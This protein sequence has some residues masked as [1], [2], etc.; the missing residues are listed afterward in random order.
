[1]PSA[2]ST[3]NST[4]PEGENPGPTARRP[5]ELRRLFRAAIGG[6]QRVSVDPA[7]GRVVVSQAIVDHMLEKPQRRDGREAF[8]PLIPE[9]LED[10]AEIW[11]GFARSAR[12]GR[13]RLRRRYVKLVRLDKRR[14]LG[15]VA[16]ADRGMWTGLTFFRG[17]PRGLDQLRQGLRVYRRGE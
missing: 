10:P 13:V 16:D 14:V 9:L 12:S 2:A 5:G 8:F 6:D 4:P 11:V 1:M 17:R 7:G 3:W 15:L